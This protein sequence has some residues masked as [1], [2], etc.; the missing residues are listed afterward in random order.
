[1]RILHLA[2]FLQGGAGRVIVDL[3]LQQHAAGDDITVVTSNTGAPGYGNYPAYVSE[4][5]GAGVRLQ[6]VE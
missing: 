5:A 3:A 2:T 4:L 1:M 6:Q